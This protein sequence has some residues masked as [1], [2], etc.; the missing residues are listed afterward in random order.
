MA[1]LAGRAGSDRF[2]KTG[3]SWKETVAT[4][5]PSGESAVGAPPSKVASCFGCARSATFHMVSVPSSSK[6]TTLTRMR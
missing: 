1:I 2:H 4:V 5:R 6:P 3:W